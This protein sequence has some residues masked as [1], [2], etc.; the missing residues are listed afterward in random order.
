MAKEKRRP[1]GDYPVGF[2]RPPEANRFKPGCS[3]N[4]AGRPKKSPEYKD[5]L[6]RIINKKHVGTEDGKRCHK[7][8]LEL[9]LNAL[10]TKAALGDRLALRE[11]INTMERLGIKLKASGKDGEVIFIIE[12]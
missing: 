10:A 1:T 6:L 3:G 8:K 7:S 5:L 11:L 9:G 12:E 2:A 4:R